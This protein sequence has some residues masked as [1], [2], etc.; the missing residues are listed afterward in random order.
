MYEEKILIGTDTISGISPQI[1]EAIAEASNT[2]A[3]PY[4][5]DIFTDECK[6]IVKNIF[7]GKVS[8]ITWDKFIDMF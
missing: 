8:N 6:D 7:V 2:K 3:L 5:H 4:G 1:L